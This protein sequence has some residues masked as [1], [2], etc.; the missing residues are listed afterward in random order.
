MTLAPIIK[1][2]LRYYRR[3]S[4]LSLLCLM[5]IALGVGILVA[6]QLINDSALASFSSTVDFLAGRATHSV[7]SKYGRIEENLF[8]RLWSNSKIK[9]AAPVI[10]VMA[11]VVEVPGEPVQFVGIDPFLDRD[12]R[13]LLPPP[14]HAVA[15]SDLFAGPVPGIYL[16]ATLMKRFGLKPANE[17][18]VLTAG[19][20]KKVRIIGPI[21]S[22]YVPGG[23]DLAV[24]DISAAQDL[25][26]RTGYIDRI[27][28]I[29]RE[30]AK[31][32]LA[33]LPESLTL[34]DANGRKA[35]LRSMLYS[36]QLN[37]AA[38]SLLALFVGTFL[39]YNFSMFSV[40][41]RRE[42]LSLLRVLGVSR[43]ELVGAFVAEAVLLG[44]V[45]S[46]VGI[47]FGYVV[48]CLSMEKVSSTISNLY[49][50][51]DAQ[52][53]HLTVPVVLIGLGVGFLATFAGTGLPAMEV[54]LAPPALGVKRQTIE[55]R[56]QRLKGLLLAIGVA[57]FLGS[58]AASWASRFSV[59]WGFVSAF[60]MTLA[61]ALFI[62]S[63]LSPFAHYAGTW[64]RKL[65]GSL[66]VFLAARTIRAS[67]SRTSIA[68]AALAVALSMTLGVDTMIHSFRRSVDAWLEGAL[69]GDLYISPAT[70]KWAHPLPDALVRS[71]SA[72]PRVEALERYST[73]S[74]TVNGRPAKLRMIDASVL[75][76]RAR[77]T[78]L[79]GKKGGWDKMERGEVFI[80]ESL[81]YRF[82][83]D[84]GDRLELSTPVGPR[85]F[86]VAAV[87]RDY[88]SDQGTIQ[89]ARPVYEK[90]WKDASVQSVAL[91][92]KRGAS[93]AE[94]R[95]SIISRYPSLDRTIVSNSKMRSDILAIFDKTFAPTATL[96]GVSLLV[97]LLGI[98]TALMAILIERSRDMTVLGYL[99]LSPK[100][101]ARINFYQALF[102]GLASFIVSIACGLV[103]AFIIIESINY[104]SFG[105][106]VDVYLDPWVFARTFVLTSLACAASSVYPTY[107]IARYRI[108]A[109]L[110]EE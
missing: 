46:I 78:F 104:R 45:G 96:E 55:D 37:L 59:F 106:S 82:G 64:L 1:F 32:L 103:L 102:M 23:D 53:A 74:I 16:S 90:I 75:R 89:I 81:G 36:F 25:F 33:G 69:Q 68:V 31:D 98:A 100:S 35:T 29:A 20:A 95:K 41:S 5:G 21:P 101:L 7:V 94:V 22:S 51:I 87:V 38:M 2:N 52:R 72:D 79:K 12:F 8:V 56:A 91:F 58:V 6:V 105:W 54:A 10:Q 9:A 44:A 34:T 107:K 80:S 92:L 43:G 85:P 27:D 3:H 4:L 15:L 65:F 49:F 83:L 48:A 73:Y 99:G 77:F 26:G 47:A 62:P 28:I 70:T 61:F 14:G 17:L 42:D 19:I 40:L 24:L 86:R 67:L 71:L 50:Y 66:E 110:P 39:I 30:G 11:N 13:T 108:F 63:F 57:C 60:A 93:A 109:S 84:V 97:A 76:D 18:T 88:S